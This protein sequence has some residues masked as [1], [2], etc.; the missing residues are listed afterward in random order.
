MLSSI[1]MEENHTFQFTPTIDGNESPIPTVASLP[2]TLSKIP[3]RSPTVRKVQLLPLHIVHQW[4][5]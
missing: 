5:Q 1:Q 3:D 2:E 4:N